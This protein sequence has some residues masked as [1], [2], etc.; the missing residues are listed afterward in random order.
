M[1]KMIDKL[2]DNA[3]DEDVKIVSMT[4]NWY[5]G[6]PILKAI[7]REGPDYNT[8]LENL[9]KNFSNLQDYT[10]KLCVIQIIESD[11]NIETPFYIQ[12]NIKYLYDEIKDEY[13]KIKYSSNKPKLD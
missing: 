4:C 3:K 13:F 5:N 11:L 10:A 8:I 9:D 7:R 2:P 6:D 12:K 1:Y